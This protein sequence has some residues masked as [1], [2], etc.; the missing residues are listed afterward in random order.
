LVTALKTTEREIVNEAEWGGRSPPYHWEVFVN[1]DQIFELENIS[2]LSPRFTRGMHPLIPSCGSMIYHK[3]ENQL[4]T[5]FLVIVRQT[6][7]QGEIV[8]NSPIVA[9]KSKTNWANFKIKKF[10]GVSKA[11]IWRSTFENYPGT[12]LQ[13]VVM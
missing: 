4:P 10:Q 2:I 13:E 9:A 12:W 8:R 6:R 5:C 7:E 1:G 3:K 11:L